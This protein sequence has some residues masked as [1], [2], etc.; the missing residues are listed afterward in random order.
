[1]ESACGC[2]AGALAGL[3]AVGL[4]VVLVIFAPGLI[5]KSSLG[6]I[7]QGALIYVVAGGIGKVLALLRIRHLRAQIRAQLNHYDVGAS[8]IEAAEPTGRH[9]LSIPAQREIL[10]VGRRP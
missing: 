4:Y 5:A 10:R 7:V 3:A 8:R 2:E 1:L 6:R 9:R